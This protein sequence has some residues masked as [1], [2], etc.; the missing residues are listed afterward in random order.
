MDFIVENFSVK[1]LKDGKY[2][3]PKLAEFTLNGQKRD[4]ELLRVGNSVAILIY[5]RDSNSFVCVKQF[6]PAVY[7]NHNINYTIELCAGLLDKDCSL[8][9]TAKEEILEE[10]GFD[11]DVNRLEYIT[12]FYTCV[13]HAGSKQH[14]FFT[15]VDESMR[16]SRG[17][18]VEGEEIIEVIEIPI[19]RAR[20]LMFD[21]NIAK[22]PG[23]L[24]AFEWFLNGRKR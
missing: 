18:G 16:V 3:S 20:E 24:F 8:E 9:Q 2:I 7:F 22:T 21:L 14:L 23:L 12:S 11:V 19:K 6:R 1:P 5:N 15:E 17:G 13:G 4:W 10:C